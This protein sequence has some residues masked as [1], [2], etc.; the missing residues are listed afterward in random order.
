MWLGT[1]GS[2]EPSLLG[3]F[4]RTSVNRTLTGKMKHK[5]LHK[6]YTQ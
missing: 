5:D 3:G 2:V 1:Y 6:I 4:M